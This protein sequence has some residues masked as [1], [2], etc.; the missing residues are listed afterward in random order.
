MANAETL[1]LKLALSGLV[2]V[3]AGFKQLSHSI[4][5]IKEAVLPLAAAFLGFK[6]IE[7]LG[8]MA[9][10]V[11]ELGSQMNVLKAR[12]GASIPELMA[13]RKILAENG[14]AAEDVTM[15]IGHMQ[16]SIEEAT[17]KGG[18]LEKVF[19]D[20]NLSVEKLST[21]S[22][23][24]QFRS[25]AEGIASI[26]SPAKKTQLAMAIFG[27][28]GGEVVGAFSNIQKVTAAFE[29]NG[30]FSQIITRNAEGFHEVEVN[31]NRLAMNG[32]KAMAGFLDQIIPEF[33]E[34]FEKL[35]NIDL[36]AI[37]Q[38]IGAF[39]AVI[40]ESIRN[41]KFPEMLGLLVQAGF[42]LGALG[43][44][45]VMREL[46]DF[47][48][49]TLLKTIAV[50]FLNGVMEYGV[51]SLKLVMNIIAPIASL[52]G[53][54]VEWLLTQITT[55]FFKFGN[56]LQ[57]V[58]V[59]A[60]NVFEVNFEKAINGA[61]SKLN[62]LTHSNF[63]N[64]MLNRAEYKPKE[65]PEAETWTQAFANNAKYSHELVDGVSKSLDD[66]L[67]SSR[68]ILK[69][70][71]GITDKDNTRSPALERI[72]A[73]I[74]EQI[75]RREQLAVV[76]K[77][78]QAPILAQISERMVLKGLEDQE[79]NLRS[80]LVQIQ[81]ERAQI[82]N[83]DTMTDAIK[84]GKRKELLEYERRTTEQI[85]GLL[86]QKAD[87]LEKTDPARADSARK[88]MIGEQ[89]KLPGI[90]KK[91][92][93]LGP[94]PNSFAEQ[95]QSVFTKLQNQF[96]TFAKQLA[97]SFESVF[98]TAVSSISNGIT[99]LITGTKT[100][101]QALVEIGN[102][103]LT[104]IIQAIV[105]MG[106][107]W[108]LTQVM[109]AVAGKAS[110][111]GTTAASAP[112]AMAQSA[113]WAA[114]ATLATISSYGGAALAAPGLIGL[115]QSIVAAQSVL[116]SGF[117]EG[118][119]TG[120][121]G[122]YQ[123]AGVVHSGEFVMPSHAVDRIGLPALESMMHGGSSSGGG[124]GGG[125]THVHNWHSEAAMLAFIQNNPQVRHHI[126][127]TVGEESHRILPRRS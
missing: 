69:I 74:N 76:E 48:G 16:K 116:S 77:V 22:P 46:G 42:E 66:Q 49:S 121:G 28:T 123:V 32:T 63:S 29:S 18:P 1:N 7:G 60:V 67:R 125:D 27:R 56:F 99:G 117:A 24:Q 20:M 31:L 111:A 94:D 85:I 5:S 88:Q 35:G 15:L 110:L 70:A 47:I 104:S 25:I 4:A 91:I 75:K 38:K 21:L 115:A 57:K 44:R 71:A 39:G 26:E 53:G 8:E 106:V 98:N 59:D 100:W 93:A 11:L 30:L 84:Y 83:D 40:I 118:G 45:V 108:V 124:G 61:I 96:G 95:F 43:A 101:G 102:T 114:P 13:I 112:I 119:Y 3:E 68:E 17:E 51:Q 37:G 52:V 126:V 82:D 36:T 19:G 113:I 73:L 50:A 87:L 79:L 97:T 64:V 62:S 81:A 55:G 109:M 103:I 34:T 89:G 122:K 105:Q 78:A 127:K 23:G 41:D 90:D 6:G 9:K 72:N 86:K 10:G 2:A 14:G 58:F 33:T 80:Q 54:T 65:V 92:G 120:S 107:R 12:I